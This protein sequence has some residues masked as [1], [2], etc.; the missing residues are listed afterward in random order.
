[1][2]E[3][4]TLAS[5]QTDWKV[6]CGSSPHCIREQLFF[7]G[8]VNRESKINDSCQTFTKGQLEFIY[9]AVQHSLTISWMIKVIMI[10]FRKEISF[11]MILIKKKVINF[12]IQ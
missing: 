1:M 2:M 11:T 8:T 7:D 4:L 6:R 10:Y 9:V 3:L 5:E 12:Q